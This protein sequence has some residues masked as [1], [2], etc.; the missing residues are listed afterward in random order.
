M[1]ILD[2]ESGKT[3]D[4]ILLMLTPSEISEL[5]SKLEGINP[6]RGDHIHVDD[7]DYIRQITALVYTKENLKF[8][9]DSVRRAIGE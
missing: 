7:E 4:L 6:E 3:I 2:I 1:R 9:D 8:F 5:I